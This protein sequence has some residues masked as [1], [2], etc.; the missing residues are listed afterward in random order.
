MSY[1]KARKRRV[2]FWLP[3]AVHEYLKGQSKQFQKLYGKRRYN[4]GD[5]ITNMCI[6]RKPEIRE[7]LNKEANL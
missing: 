6:D 4:M 7:W 2:C 3:I 5:L 1:F